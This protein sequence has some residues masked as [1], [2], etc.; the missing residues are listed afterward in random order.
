MPPPPPPPPTT[1]TTTTYDLN[2]KIP[3]D[4]NIND[5]M[6]ILKLKCKVS[7]ALSSINV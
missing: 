2:I 5:D 6:A 3:Y 4:L 1:T 7:S